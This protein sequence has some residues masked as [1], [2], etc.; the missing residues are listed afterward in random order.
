M[1]MADSLDVTGWIQNSVFYCNAGAAETTTENFPGWSIVT[2]LADLDLSKGG[3]I[4]D[5]YGWEGKPTSAENPVADRGVY[6]GGNNNEYVS[7]DVS[8]QLSLLPVGTFTYYIETC[9]RTGRNWNDGSPT[10]DDPDPMKSYVYYFV[11]EDNKA[12]QQF[13]HVEV[14]K[15]QW[16]PLDKNYMRNISVPATGNYAT[17]KIGANLMPFQDKNHGEVDNAKLYMTAKDPSFDYGAAAEAVRKDAT[18]DIQQVE[19]R[20]DAPVAVSY[21]NM[22]GQQMAAPKGVSLK[23]ESYSDGYVVVKKVLVK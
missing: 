21:F 12:Q 19:V 23:V 11:S 3:Y 4:K 8:Q 15:N 9:D 17:F 13:A 10:V 6:A 20:T 22:A 14:D 16:Y 18:D 7:V 2:N 1:D 5:C